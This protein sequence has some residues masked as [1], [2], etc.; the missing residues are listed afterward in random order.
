MYV[1]IWVLA[2]D[3]VCRCIKI[4]KWRVD[5]YIRI[6]TYICTYMCV[7]IYACECWCVVIVIRML[8][9]LH[10]NARV[11]TLTPSSGDYLS[12]I[13]VIFLGHFPQKSPI[14][15]GSF[16]EN[17]LQAHSLPLAVTLSVAFT[18]AWRINGKAWPRGYG[19]YTSRIRV[20]HDSF[21]CG[22]THAHVTWFVHVRHNMTHET[23]LYMWF[24]ISFH[25]L[26]IWFC[27]SF[28]V[29]FYVSFFHM[30]YIYEIQFLQNDIT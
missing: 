27:V 2:C 17:D 30:W 22:M 28:L 25:I 1:F 20:W 8:S 14:I 6:Y 10:N 21:I 9:S 19:W 15:S 4:P 3:H 5:I 18:Y 12:C 7:Y 11:H 29:S 24:C 26:Y 13:H 23:I 16:A